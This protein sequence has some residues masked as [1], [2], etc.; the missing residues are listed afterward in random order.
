MSLS[1]LTIAE[2]QNLLMEETQKFTRALREGCSIEEKEKMRQKIE[3]V[4]KL[5]E[6]KRHT[7]GTHSKTPEQ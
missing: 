3:E 4:Q 1:N 2:L 7:N 5:I 6:E